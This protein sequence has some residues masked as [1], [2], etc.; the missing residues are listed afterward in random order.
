V[1]YAEVGSVLIARSDGH[2]SEV[3]FRRLE[4]NLRSVA[5]RTGGKVGLLFLV[6]HSLGPAPGF[7]ENAKRVLLENESILAGVCAVLLPEGFVAALYRSMGAMLVRLLDRRG[8]VQVCGNVDE[9]VVWLVPRLPQSV[10]RPAPRALTDAANLLLAT[11]RV[12][13]RVAV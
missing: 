7:V 11:Q 9:G 4:S 12:A 5:R 1:Q 13:R 10:H 8:V 2:E 6:D 3:H